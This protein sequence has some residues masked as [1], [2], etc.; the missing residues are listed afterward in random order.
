MPNPFVLI[1]RTDQIL[2]AHIIKGR[3]E[4]AGVNAFVFDDQMLSTNWL[5]SEALGGVRV[6]VLASQLDEAREVLKENVTIQ[7]FDAFDTCPLCHSHDVVR[8]KPP[9]FFALLTYLLLGFLYMR[10]TN[11]RKCRSCAHQWVVKK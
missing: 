8:L 3:L 5:Y 10:E 6:M 1:L 9:L 7:D 2:E 11:N 4:A